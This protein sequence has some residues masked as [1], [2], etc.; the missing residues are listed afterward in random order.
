[1]TLPVTKIFS[2]IPEIHSFEEVGEYLQ[3]LKYE[4]EDTYQNQT[5][6]INGFYR[7]S[8]EIDGSK[9]IPTISGSVSTDTID[10]DT[11]KAYVLRSGLLVDFW[12]FVQWTSIGSSAGALI[13]DLPYKV[14]K[15]FTFVGCAQ[16]G[17][18][19]GGAGGLIFPGGRTQITM[20]ADADSFNGR[21]IASGSA[22]GSTDIDIQANAYIS[23]YLRYIGVEDE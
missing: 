3:K 2:P 7:N 18:S 19:L 14:T 16:S 9:F 22:Q 4:L 8:E 15:S 20:Q 1:M 21:I 12:F 10:Y 23:G 5:Q 13:V 11:Q 6:N 17:A